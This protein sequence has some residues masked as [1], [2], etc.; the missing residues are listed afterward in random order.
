MLGGFSAIVIYLSMTQ[1]YGDQ[2]FNLWNPKAARVLNALSEPPVENS[3][4]ADPASQVFGCSHSSWQKGLVDT[5]QRNLKLARAEAAQLKRPGAARA[6]VETERPWAAYPPEIIRPPWMKTRREAQLRSAGKLDVF[7]DFQFA[8][9][10]EESGIRFRNRV[11]ADAGKEFKPVHYDHGNGI[12]ITDVDGDDLYDIYFVNQVGGNELW[13]NLG[14]GR[15]ENIT[16]RAGVALNDRVCVSA[17]FADIDN[18]GDPDLYVTSVRNG[19]VLFEND[20]TGKFRDISKQSGLDHQGHSSGAVFFDYDRDGLID[21]FLTNVGKYTTD[22]LATVTN[23]STSGQEGTNYQYYIGI[24]DA[25]AGHLKPELFERSILFKNMGNNRFADRSNEVGL[26]HLGWSGDASPVDVNEDGWPDLYVLNM[27]GN[28]EYYQNVKGEHF[29]RKS[30]EVFPKTPWGSMGI[31][32]FDYN[33]D[34]RMDIFVTDMHS[35]MWEHI[36]PEREKLKPRAEVVPDSSLL[37]SNGA[38]LFGNA[39]YQNEG[40]GRFKEVADQIGA[41]NYWPWGLSVGDL[42]ADGHEDVFIASSM[43]FPYRYGVNSVLLNNRGRFFDSEFILGVE[44]RRGNRTARPWFELD[45]SGSDQAHKFCGGQSGRIVIW[46]AVGTRSS[47]IFDLDNDGDLDIVTNDLN[48]EPMVLIS[49][50]TQK[51]S[52][53]YLKVKL[54]GA[55]SNRSGLGAKVRVRVGSRTYTQVLDG[56]S[57]YLSQSL[58]PLYFGLGESKSVDQI[59][60]LWP[61]SQK[62]VLFGPIKANSMIEVKEQPAVGRAHSPRTPTT[63]RASISCSQNQPICVVYVNPVIFL[64][65]IGG[66]NTNTK[67][68]CLTQLRT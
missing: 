27:Q 13:R 54:I 61:S 51:K 35:D 45:C 8:D 55:K 32:V 16:H 38:S 34:G 15:F 50:L 6:V 57:G 5:L 60:V 28:D 4:R 68:A 18:D 41:E 21:L 42:N 2:F 10:I 25:F 3:V 49:N 36:G 33:N 29:V 24:K 43:N 17:S 31:K 56:K 48:S 52:I 22:V 39:F 40:G 53:H 14:G 26:I 7:C 66:L 37:G 47:V 63:Q 62:Q 64:G 19:N 59:E 65:K 9:L 44:P 67:G 58:Y 1:P 11:V 46:G 12:A 23:D 20:G 30:R